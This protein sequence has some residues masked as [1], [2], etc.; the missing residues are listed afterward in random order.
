MKESRFYKLFF[1]FG[2]MR[3]L[4]VGDPH[5]ELGKIKKL[6]SKKIDLVLCTGDIGKADFA[7]KRFF[8]NIERKRKGLE[9]LDYDLD[10]TIG[11]KM[12][13]LESD[14]NHMCITS[15][16]RF[17]DNEYKSQVIFFKGKYICM[18]E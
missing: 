10:Y 9:E 13:T 1:V 14:C 7:R 6:D 5:G 12:T 8:E 3:I 18:C 15:K 16:I 4:V 2:G 17:V 11:A